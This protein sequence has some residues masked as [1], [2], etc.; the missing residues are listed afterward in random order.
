MWIGLIWL[1]IWS[2]CGLL[3]TQQWTFLFYKKQGVSWLALQLLASEEDLCSMKVVSFLCETK[4]ANYNA[5]Y[6]LGP[7]I[8][9]NVVISW[10]TFCIGFVISLMLILGW[11]LKESIF[12]NVIV[13]IKSSGTWQHIWVLC[14]FCCSVSTYSMS[15]LNSMLNIKWIVKYFK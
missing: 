11:Y 2:T 6:S 13:N 12:C 1:R 3:W 5:K 15:T 9:S 10:L 14:A 8:E 4:W 7:W